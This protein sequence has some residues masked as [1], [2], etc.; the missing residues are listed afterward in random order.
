MLQVASASYNN[1]VLTP[2]PCKL[3]HF[4]IEKVKL[5]NFPNVHFSIFHL[6]LLHIYKFSF[7][8]LTFYFQTI[9][10]LLPFNKSC[11]SLVLVL[12]L[13]SSFHDS[14]NT[15]LSFSGFPICITMKLRNLA[16]WR[17]LAFRWMNALALSLTFSIL[18]NEP[19]LIKD[20]LRRGEG[21]EGAFVKEQM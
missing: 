16:L 17:N 11:F 13:H 20:L 14:L 7:N 19:F 21:E 4:L 15:V 6:Y 2:P 18:S 8:I 3:L 9:R 5:I 12:F 1:K 10:F